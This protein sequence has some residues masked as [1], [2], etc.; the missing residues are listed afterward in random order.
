M[1]IAAESEKYENIDTGIVVVKAV[2]DGEEDEDFV[3]NKPDIMG[4]SKKMFMKNRP[5]GFVFELLSACWAVRSRA[6]WCRMLLLAVRIWIDKNLK[7][8]S[9][10]TTVMNSVSIAFTIN[11]CVKFKTMIT[12][13]EVSRCMRL[14]FPSMPHTGIQRPLGCRRTQRRRYSRHTFA[15]CLNLSEL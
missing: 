13:R 5:S 14:R 1:A 11:N 3:P 4:L 10:T 15:V 8:S 12:P 2:G 7:V 6:L 9:T